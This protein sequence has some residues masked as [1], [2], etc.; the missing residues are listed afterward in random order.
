EF[1]PTYYGLK[2]LSWTGLI[3]GLKAVP[4]SVLDEGAQ[5]EHAASVAAAQRAALVHPDYSAFK[6]VVPAAAALA[7]VTVPSSATH[8]TKRSAPPAIHCNVSE[9]IQATPA[10]TTPLRPE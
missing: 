7:M 8:V 5:A 3:W 2:L 4:Q 9:Q 10:R 6:K 1:D